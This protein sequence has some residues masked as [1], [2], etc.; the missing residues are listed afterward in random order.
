MKKAMFF[1]LLAMVVAGLAPG[2]VAVMPMR[3]G[4]GGAA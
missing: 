3:P 4:G 1:L 2:I